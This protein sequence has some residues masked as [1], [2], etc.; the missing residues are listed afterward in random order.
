[1]RRLRRVAIKG[2]PEAEDGKGDDAGK[3]RESAIC[4]TNDQKR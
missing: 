3:M 2:G 1:L 4:R